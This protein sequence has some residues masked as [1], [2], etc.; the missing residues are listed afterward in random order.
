MSSTGT[1]VVFARQGCYARARV[2]DER[3]RESLRAHVHVHV[4]VLQLSGVAVQ[5]A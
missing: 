3:L 4:E 1:A 5:R 2:S